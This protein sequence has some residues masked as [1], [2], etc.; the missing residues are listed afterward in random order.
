VSTSPFPGP[1]SGTNYYRDGAVQAYDGITQ[2]IATTPSLVYTITFFLNDSGFLTTF[3]RLSDNGNTS[4]N[5]GNG[6]DL[7]VYAGAVPTLA[8]VPEPTTLLLLGAGLAGLGLA[9][10]RRSS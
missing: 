2:G 10:R 4:D 7:L 3:K 9:R 5:G 8:P 6:I 1:H